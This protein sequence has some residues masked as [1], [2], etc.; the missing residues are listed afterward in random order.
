M[1]QFALMSGPLCSKNLSMWAIPSI[2]TVTGQSLLK[3]H[4][5]HYGR[6]A[7]SNSCDLLNSFWS[8]PGQRTRSITT[9]PMSCQV[10]RRLR[11]IRPNNLGLAL[12]L[13]KGCQEPLPAS[14]QHARPT[15]LTILYYEKSTL[16]LL[17]HAYTRV[18]RV[19]VGLKRGI[20]GSLELVPSSHV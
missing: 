5:V 9:Q 13:P 11:F 4:L 12:D 10:H 20:H 2:E 15:T 17:R 16:V 19:S 1:G 14:I 6:V 8:L 7:P 3:A 18:Y